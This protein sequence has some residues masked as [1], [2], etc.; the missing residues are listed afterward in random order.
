MPRST[1]RTAVRRMHIQAEVYV[2]GTI[3]VHSPVDPLFLVIPI[4]LALATKVSCT[5]QPKYLRS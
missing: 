4:V 5:L 3:L 1:V 2:A